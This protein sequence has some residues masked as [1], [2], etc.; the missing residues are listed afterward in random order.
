MHCTY[1]DLLFFDSKYILVTHS[2]PDV[3]LYFPIYNITSIMI[4]GQTNIK[5]RKIDG[6]IKAVGNKTSS[7]LSTLQCNCVTRQAS[8]PAEAH[9]D[10]FRL[11][12][13]QPSISQLHC[14]QQRRTLARARATV[15]VTVTV[16]RG[17]W[18]RRCLQCTVTT[19][20]RLRHDATPPRTASRFHTARQFQVAGPP[21]F[22]SHLGEEDSQLDSGGVTILI[23]SNPP[24]RAIRVLG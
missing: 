18:T 13:I 1:F 11:E 20:L 5:S 7:L 21:A 3:L 19:S 14:P 12:S 10:Q 15:T 22:P 23:R 17:R 6:G 8:K 24:R 16:N 4:M 2:L 9:C